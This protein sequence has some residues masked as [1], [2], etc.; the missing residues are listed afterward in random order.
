MPPATTR[1]AHTSANAGTVSGG[2]ATTANVRTPRTKT[3]APT[4]H[5]CKWERGLTFFV[6]F[7]CFSL[8]KSWK[9]GV[10]EERLSRQRGWNSFLCRGCQS[11]RITLLPHCVS[12][13]SF[14]DICPGQ[15]RKMEQSNVKYDSF[16]Q[17]YWLILSSFVHAAAFL[18]GGG[19]GLRALQ[20]R[21]GHSFS[22]G[23]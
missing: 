15:S 21:Q 3:R 14:V 10:R 17:L 18:W 13:Y 11:K 9:T 22:T 5:F 16:Q 1:Q 8:K 4:P 12:L 2:W 19:G 7:S 20:L 23:F 6:F